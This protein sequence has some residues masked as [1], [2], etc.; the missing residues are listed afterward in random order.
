MEV[1][2]QLHTF[3][4]SNERVKRELK[5]SLTYAVLL[6]LWK[7]V[8]KGERVLRPLWSIGSDRPRVLLF[9]GS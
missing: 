2:L 8:G 9:A 4:P 6:E 7:L 5:A 1:C 3:N